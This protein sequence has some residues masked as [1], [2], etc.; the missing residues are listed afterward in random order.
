MT[1]D[2]VTVQK[3]AVTL[4]STFVFIAVAVEA[5]HVHEVTSCCDIHCSPSGLIFTNPQINTALIAAV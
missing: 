5:E 2:N 1:Q 3:P 4:H